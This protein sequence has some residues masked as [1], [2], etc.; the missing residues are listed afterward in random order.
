[1]MIATLQIWT[2]AVVMLVGPPIQGVSTEQQHESVRTRG[3]SGEENSFHLDM[4]RNAALGIGPSGV[5][6]PE[7]EGSI[8]IIARLGVDERSRLRNWRRLHNVRSYLVEHGIPAERIVTAEGVSRGSL[9]TVEVFL[10]GQLRLTIT[11]Q[12]DKDINVDCCEEFSKYYPWYKGPPVL[13]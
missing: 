10:G 4:I 1:M 5:K 6:V 7:I 11:A 12:R 9:A 2:I 8:I 3:S 13:D